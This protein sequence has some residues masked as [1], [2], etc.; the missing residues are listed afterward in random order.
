MLIIIHFNFKK[1][2]LEYAY[3]KYLFSKNKY[4]YINHIYFC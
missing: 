1:M 4:V 2:G 3:S